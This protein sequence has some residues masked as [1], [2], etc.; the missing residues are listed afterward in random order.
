MIDGNNQSA[1]S[2]WSI[3]WY[4][5]KSNKQCLFLT[6]THGTFERFSFSTY[7]SDIKNGVFRVGPGKATQ[8]VLLIKKHLFSLISM[9]TAIFIFLWIY[10]FLLKMILSSQKSW[11]LSS[12]Y[13]MLPRDYQNSKRRIGLWVKEVATL[14]LSVCILFCFRYLDGCI[15]SDSE[16]LKEA[17]FNQAY[18]ASN[19]QF[20]NWEKRRLDREEVFKRSIDWRESTNSWLHN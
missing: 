2:R 14:K 20:S 18:A 4:T 12:R 19:K 8:Q 3:R 5:C 13:P 7:L 11:K 10:Y 15:D 6:V 9:E 16:A 1:C 17:I